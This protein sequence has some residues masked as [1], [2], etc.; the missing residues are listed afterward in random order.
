LRD[1]PVRFIDAF[2]DEL[3]FSARVCPGRGEGD[4]RPGYA[5]ADL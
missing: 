4:G 1:N 3:D 2:V 5:P